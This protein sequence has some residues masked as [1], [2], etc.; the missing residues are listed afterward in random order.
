[1][2]LKEALFSSTEILKQKTRGEIRLWLYPMVALNILVSIVLPIYLIIVTYYKEADSE[3]KLGGIAYL[4]IGIILLAAHSRLKKRIKAWI[5]NKRMKYVLLGIIKLIPLL[6]AIFVIYVIKTDTETF[7]SLI[8]KL[9]GLY[10]GHMVISYFS[11]PLAAE[12]SVRDEL[13]FK[14]QDRIID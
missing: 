11:D 8:D 14:S 9:I 4:L 2:K 1:M 3:F 7:V 6:A 5:T 13:R 12:L 10:F